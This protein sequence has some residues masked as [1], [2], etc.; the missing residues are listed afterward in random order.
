MING[1]SILIVD[2]EKNTCEG[3]KRYLSSYEYDV[4]AVFSGEEA[5]EYLS[6]HSPDLI[7]TDLKM[8]S[9]IDGLSLLEEIKKRKLSS[10]V[11]M[12]TAYGTVENAVDAM[13]KGA[14]HYLTKPI[15]LDELVL[16]IKKALSHKFL[17]SENKELKERL[18]QS[19]SSNLILGTSKVFKKIYEEALQ[20][21]ESN[22]SVMIQGES[23]TGKELVAQLVHQKS[24]RKDSPFIPV[25]CAALSEHLLESELFGHEKGAFTGAIERKIGRFEKA[26]TGTIFLDEIGEIDQKTQVK[27]L[28]VLQDGEF[29]RVGGTKTIRSDIRLIVATNKNLLEEVKK[30]AFREDLY[31][32][33]NVVV[34]TVP[35]LRERKEDIKEI[36]DY[37]VDK[38]S[39]EKVDLFYQDWVEKAV[40]G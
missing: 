37:Y 7:L 34:L 31:Y 1:T 9:G 40:C 10:I 12:M 36:F 23:G 28:R 24:A 29:E 27:L 26:H 18:Y 38:F 21:A 20:V 8:G 5:L 11:I 15:N 6:S 13:Q 35:P 2:D 22:A 39:V 3:L 4:H 14:Y 19:F 30:G 32:R 33:I 25:H 16:V 17:E